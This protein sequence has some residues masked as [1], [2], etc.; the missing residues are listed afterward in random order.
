[1]SKTF[2]EKILRK[3]TKISI[4]VFPRLFLFYRVFGCFSRREPVIFGVEFVYFLYFCFLVDKVGALRNFFYF[5]LSSRRLPHWVPTSPRMHCSQ[6]QRVLLANLSSSA[7]VQFSFA[8]AFFDL[9][10]ITFEV[11]R[12]LLATSSNFARWAATFS[13]TTLFFEHNYQRN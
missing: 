12:S 1:M 13:R 7:L 6:P 9:T 5:F 2:S 11:R 3:S 10:T 8:F 4:S